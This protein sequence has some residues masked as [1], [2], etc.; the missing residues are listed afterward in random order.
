MT[1]IDDE[2]ISVGDPLPEIASVQPLEKFNVGVTWTTGQYAEVDLAPDILTFRPY[3]PL[4]ANPILFGTVHVANEGAAIAWGAADAIDM[5]ATA[6]ERLAT[7]VMTANDLRAFMATT[8]LTRDGLAAQLGIS[9][10]LLGYYIEGQQI[11]RYISLAC[12]QLQQRRV[13]TRV[14]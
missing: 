3:A 11:P 6:I 5:P 7:E 4:R 1:K 12:A 9:R 8:K 2:I 14:E 10:R 13:S